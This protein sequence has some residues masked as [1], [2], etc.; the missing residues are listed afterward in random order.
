MSPIPWSINDAIC[1][2]EPSI[3]LAG[4]QINAPG[5]FWSTSGDG[6]FANATDMTTTYSFGTN[7]YSNGQVTLY[8]NTD[9][10]QYTG[11]QQG[12]PNLADSLII[13]I[14]NVATAEVGSNQSFCG[15]NVPTI[16]LNGDTTNADSLE[17]RIVSG[18]SGTFLPSNTEEDPT[19]LLDAF[20]STIANT[21]V[22]ELRARGDSICAAATDQMTI[23]ISPE[24]TIDA[25]ND[26]AVCANNP[27]INLSGTITEL[28]DVQ[29]SGGGGAFG[30]AQN[31]NTSYTLT[32]AEIASG[33]VQLTLSSRNEGNCNP[34]SDDLLIS[35][36]PAPTVDAGPDLVTCQT[37]DSVAV[38]GSYDTSISSGVTWTSSG[39]GSFANP[40][41]PNTTYILGPNDQS[42]NDTSTVVLTLTTTGSGNCNEESDTKNLV[43]TP[44]PVIDA[45]TN[46][47][48]CITNPNVS[49]AGTVTA[50]NG[51]PWPGGGRWESPT[52]PGSFVPN[53]FDPNATFVPNTSAILANTPFPIYFY[54]EGNGNCDAVNDSVL[55][56]WINPVVPEAGPDLSVCANNPTANITVSDGLGQ[57]P[58]VGQVWTS[59]SGHEG[60]GDS[61]VKNT[62]YT[63][64]GSEVNAGSATLYV[65]YDYGAGFN[66]QPEYD[67]VIINVTP[68]PIVDAGPDRSIC[69]NADTVDLSG[70][71]TGA[72][73]GQ[74][75]VIGGGGSFIPNNSDLNASFTPT[76]PVGGAT[77]DL[78]LTTTGNGNCLAER[79][80]MTVTVNPAPTMNIQSSASTTCKNNPA[81]NLR[82]GLAGITVAT[83][84][85][86]SRI[87]S[88]T[89]GSFIPDNTLNPSQDSVRYVPSQ[90]DLDNDSVT[91]VGV[92]TGNGDCNPIYDTV[93]IYFSPAP[94]VDAG[95]DDTICYNNPTVN[96]SGAVTVA[97][98][99]TWST[100]GG[101]TFSNPN[102]LNTS[103]T[104]TA[105]E[106]NSSQFTLTLT[107]TGNGN[108][109]PE[110]DQV[111]IFVR[112]APVVNAGSNITACETVNIVTLNGTFSN[113]DG[114]QWS[115]V[116]G[117]GSFVGGTDTLPNAQYQVTTADKNNGE[118]VLRAA[119]R[120]IEE[121]NPVS[122]QLRITFTPA[123][124]LSAGSNQVVCTNDFPV[125]LNGSSS[126][127]AS[128]QGG[129]GSFSPN[130]NS[131]SAQYTPAPSEVGS[132]VTLVLQGTAQGGCPAFT[133]SVELDIRQ[134]PSVS[135]SGDLQKCAQVSE[136]DL[137]ATFLGASGIEWD[138][139][140]GNGSFSPNPFATSVNYNVTVF[141]TTQDS[142]VFVVRTT[143][144]G[145]CSPARDTLTVEFL[146]PLI[147]SA[148]ASQTVCADD[149][150]VQLNGYSSTPAGGRWSTTNGSG[151]FSPNVNQDDAIYVFDPSDKSLDSIG[152]VFTTRGVPNVCSAIS[153]TAYIRFVQPPV[154]NAGSDLTVCADTN[155][156]ALSG[157]VSNASGG[158]WATTGSGT[159]SLN[160]SSLNTTYV[161]SDADTAA[162]TV[163]LV[164]ST[165]G[166]SLCGT[167]R[168]TLTLTITP[169]VRVDLG[170]DTVMC[171]SE[172]SINLSPSV[173][174][175]TGGS[176]TT[177][178]TG[179]FANPNQ[180]NT[181]YTP[182]AADKNNGFVSLTLST[183][184]NGQCQPR[185]DVLGINFQPV[186]VV[187]AGPNQ[188]TC[189][190]VDSIR[191]VGNLNNATTGAWSTSGSGN[192][193]NGNTTEDTYVISTADKSNGS[194]E[195]YFQATNTGACTA[196]QDTLVLTI[197]PSPTADAGADQTI[198]ADSAYVDLNGASISN[199]SGQV[200]TST[201]TGQF[202]PSAS[203]LAANYVPS[204]QDTANGSVS[205]ILQT[206]G[207]GACNPALDTMQVTIQ[208]APAVDAGGDQTVCAAVDSVFLSGTFRNAGGVRWRTS[209]TGTFAPSANQADARYIPSAQDTAVRSVILTLTST[210]NGLCN[211]VSDQ[212]TVHFTPAPTVD[213]GPDRQ[214]CYSEA[215]ITLA[216]FYR[217]AGGVRWTHDG[218]GA[219]TPSA[220]RDTTEYIFVPADI[221]R[222]LTFRVQTTNNGICSAVSDSFTLYIRPVPS[223]DAGPDQTVCA[224]VGSVPL[225]GD[226]SN[227]N[228]ILWTT[229]GDG[230]FLPGATSIDPAYS[231]GTNDIANGGV[232]LYLSSVGAGPCTDVL[233]SM[234]IQVN[235]A[236]TLAINNDTTVC[237]DFEGITLNATTNGVPGG[238]RW[239]TSGSGVFIPHDSASNPIYSPST[240]DINSGGVTINAATIQNGLCQAVNA[241][242]SLTIT[243][244][245]T[246]TVDNDKLLCNT[247]DT[248]VLSGTITVAPGGDW[249]TNGSGTFDD[250][251]SLNTVYRFSSADKSLD[252]VLFIL[253]AVDKGN[254][255]D[256]SDRFS[257]FWQ[258]SIRVEAGVNDTLCADDNNGYALNGSISNASGASWSTSGSGSF[259][260]SA[261]D[262]NATYYPSAADRSAGDV[263]LYLSTTD[264]GLCADVTDSL[265]IH[266]RPAP[267]VDAGSDQTICQDH[268]G[269]VAL[270]GTVNASVENILWTSSGTG[271]FDNATSLTANYTPSQADL[272]SLQPITLTLTTTSQYDCQPVISSMTIDVT[273]APTIDAGND[274]EVCAG[275]TSV[276][277]SVS[278]TVASGVSWSVIG[279]STGTFSNP[280]AVNTDYQPVDGVD[281]ASGNVVDI[282]VVTTGVGVCNPVADTISITFDTP[283]NADAGP[284]Q[285]V[286]T[287]QLPVQL[288]ASNTSGIWSGG[289]G[290]FIPNANT[291]NARYEPTS[292]ELSSGS[293]TLT[294]SPTAPGTCTPGAPDDV[295]ITFIQGPVVDAGADDTVCAND[296]LYSLSGTVGGSGTGGTWTSNGTGS[297][298]PNA[299]DLS[300]DYIPS[301]QDVSNG[302]VR[303]ILTSTGGTCPS[304]RDTM[305]LTITPTPVVDAGADRSICADAPSIPLTG[306]VSSEAGGGTWSVQSGSGSFSPHPDTLNASYVPTAADTANGF[307]VLRLTSR[308]NGRCNPVSDTMRIDFTDAPTISA[309]ADFTV[310][311]DTGSIQLN[312]QV[313]VANG[314]QW[315]TTGN[316]TFSP[317]RNV[318][319][320]TYVLSNGD[321]AAGSI[322]FYLV[323]TGNG[324]CQQVE[325]SF[326]LNI[327]PAVQIQAGND[328]TVC[329]DVGS[330]PLSGNVNSAAGGVVWTTSSPSSDP[331]TFTPSATDPN[332]NYQPSSTDSLNRSVTLTLTSTGSGL[333]RE[334]SDNMRIFFTPAPTV[335]V[336]GD[337]TAC[338]DVDSVQLGGTYDT[339]VSSGVLWSANGGDGSFVP[340]PTTLDA[341]YVPGSADSASGSVTLTLSTTG[342][343]D[344]NEVSKD[345]T[346]TLTPAP[347]LDAGS[348]QTVCADDPQV[349]LNPSVNAVVQAVA[350]DT[351]GIT[352]RFTPSPYVAN[353]TYVASN[354]DTANGQVVLYLNSTSVG[355]CKQVRDSMT[356]TILP[357]PAI[358]A[359]ADDTI[360]ASDVESQLS[361]RLKEITQ[362][363]W[364]SS[365]TGTFVPNANDPNARYRPSDQDDS[366]GRVDLTFTSID[367]GICLE[368]QDVTSLYID[369]IPTSVVNAGLDQT[370]CADNRNVILT[371]QIT[372]AVG[373]QWQTSGTGSFVPN[374]STLTATYVPSDG[375]TAAGTVVLTLTT[376]EGIGECDPVA[377]SM[378]LT[379]LPAPT[380]NAGNDDTVC[381]D[382]NAVALSPSLSA[383]ISA[384]EWSTSGTGVFTP[385]RFAANAAYIPSAQ[386]KTQ[387]TVG[388]TIRST[389]Q[390][391][392]NPVQDNKTLYITPT[393]IVD[394][395]SNQA[396]CQDVD[397]VYLSG[398]VLN[399]G[400]GQW[401]S[402]GSGTF[403]NASNLNTAYVPSA[404]ERN[405]G[406]AVLTLTST[407]NGLCNPVSDQLRIDMRP[408][409]SVDVGPDI[410]ICADVD[411]IPLSVSLANA[412]GVRWS[413]NGSGSFTPSPNVNGAAYVPSQAERN[414]LATIEIYATTTAG[415]ETCNPITDTMVVNLTPTPVVD[416]DDA[417]LC[418]DEQDGLLLFG[419]ATLAGAPIG[420]VW[421]TSGTGSFQPSR[422]SKTARYFP[423]QAD[424][425]SG[426]VVVT[427]TSVDNGSC[428]A[429]SKSASL[430]ITDL[431]TAYAGEDRFVCRGE[432]TSLSA[433][434]FKDIVGYQWLA[435]SG[436][437][438]S[439]SFSV[440]NLVINTDTSFV[441]RVTDDEGCEVYDTIQVFA[442]DPPTLNLPAAYCLD[443]NMVLLDA[444]PSAS[445]PPVNGTYTWYYEDTLLANQDGDTLVAERPGSY[446]VEYNFSF[447]SVSA[448]TEVNAAEEI[449]GEDKFVCVGSSTTLEVTDISGGTYEWQAEDGTVL[450]S[451]GHTQD[452]AIDFDSVYTFYVTMTDAIDCRSFDT[453]QVT[454]V[455]SPD[456]P[457][458]DTAI[459][460]GESITLVGQP[461][462]AVDTSGE[463]IYQWSR[464]GQ[465]IQLDNTGLLEV[466]ETG[467]YTLLYELG[468]CINYDTIEVTVHPLPVRDTTIRRFFQFCTEDPPAEPDTAFAYSTEVPEYTFTW[469]DFDSLQQRSLPITQSGPLVFQITNQFGC[470]VLDT[471]QID[472]GCPV[473][474]YVPDGFMPG[475]GAL[476]EDR[477]WRV[478][479]KH[480]DPDNFELMVFSRWGE[481]I[482]YTNNPYVGWDGTYRGR[483]MPA[484]TYNYILKFQPAD[485]EAT[486]KEAEL[487]R[488]AGE[489]VPESMQNLPSKGPKEVHGSVILVR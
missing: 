9:S 31:L 371:G 22:V 4:Q 423:S 380:I 356:V 373:G 308:L 64:S 379:I 224:D 63:L 200:W 420:A 178:G 226:S 270:T 75:S 323:S 411:S 477:E 210:S 91:I 478:F 229:S 233:D 78:V 335:S 137:S 80:T 376:T 10:A 84:A 237:A 324:S 40:T 415:I 272:D 294:F 277:L 350:W 234:H 331:G 185:S 81:F 465:V 342:S 141:D 222:T 353:A 56:T 374:D 298:S 198:C 381:A 391:I 314:G 426:S 369:P 125:Q 418:A 367:H 254:C 287:N 336:I 2:S 77:Y 8:L 156:V 201:G 214:A 159:F 317:N 438:L 113:A 47:A 62:T 104:P 119:S 284:D 408:I 148:G 306:S 469:V 123:G 403:V 5:T 157:S 29:W 462:N 57:A 136:I 256:V 412:T 280:S 290:N 211:A 37:V 325:D 177:S 285:S 155:G 195:L 316:G 88:G 297:F 55:I 282:R 225:D 116:T 145:A 183:T 132:V 39:D 199:A 247:Q 53:Q 45:G 472:E 252:S 377:D 347:S 112:P 414:A 422:F 109:V 384:I 165:T 174:V 400:G 439:D 389:A 179:T 206:T 166:A 196:I 58:S 219:F 397:T 6:S 108:C 406:Y 366:L 48:V 93:T 203:T 452:V 488:E 32:P 135:I 213:A 486:R 139:V 120:G 3:Q 186:P 457:N 217:N 100:S 443:T 169:V 205:L 227:L 476:E 161:P 484:G 259:A 300:A 154:A 345:L 60:F 102:Q 144:N 348:D 74:W 95:S 124:V 38:S 419:T 35:V 1:S 261:N 114:L 304:E 404:A 453:L 483:D 446:R 421:S 461:D 249:Q 485:L 264:N 339:T 343:G 130:R 454:G 251:D 263:T 193:V 208:P 326:Q 7:D 250:E 28:T 431:P 65:R 354:Q 487:L 360:C 126:T 315:S 378:Q 204:D 61:T 90:D 20:D 313:T 328:T 43:I 192:F 111:T 127:S 238:V 134:G 168:D 70:S 362:G 320:P 448:T 451:S 334:R 23:A 245:P 89:A 425:Q 151:S 129:N 231:L 352:G 405:Q 303:L 51:N 216:P 138:V 66:C 235:P 337:Q 305:F 299:L 209:G 121:C 13:D 253:T 17:W 407:D 152:V 27:T 269:S 437:V 79:D 394:A 73:G 255:I 162:G 312:G 295:L 344:C 115:I 72:T 466:S 175:A 220:T 289:S 358:F 46:Q 402:S 458:T 286:C 76:N 278:T 103:Y 338:S 232:M 12:C 364:N 146:D 236:P 365:G 105:T 94:T 455:P 171:S 266:I 18:G 167:R 15:N 242:M 444:D 340:G 281:N 474:V 450:S 212:M 202:F 59:A 160:S 387:G 172:T 25:G 318:L 71:V 96:L 322:M 330:I 456:F 248:V 470:S 83:G 327:D 106:L 409:P 133:D 388:L 441:L 329:A 292:A 361:G 143:G 257:V 310:C 118:V 16:A 44:G 273:P 188:T 396:L 68:E 268:T 386:D 267:T 260:P 190:N 41:D 430:V 181:S 471:I 274:I 180:L 258:D 372:V 187:D 435:T 460:N 36:T 429:Y 368:K 86:L 21:I 428:K 67:T 427:L 399:A 363:V 101:G 241:S 307:V 26:T 480:M 52:L 49:L 42:Q 128:W 149:V 221:G 24:P 147:V 69:A 296:S 275:L 173:S 228:Q 276:P 359:G 410:D 311:A 153:D 333:C 445:N 34:V 33:S 142:L 479:G 349:Q 383:N 239:S 434:T 473:T 375:D 215:R 440:S 288:N 481:I 464:D 475:D 482:F 110:Q 99:G 191:V 184:G 176:W 401:T 392:C 189:E 293:V 117:T 223:V 230:A 346:I 243:E 164:L 370:I 207:N 98:G 218:G 341:V 283:P 436:Q 463:A 246:V 158:Q 194:V 19:L 301:A 433:Q 82:V 459:C 382:Q 182:S 54:S 393:P 489:P 279:G 332:A 468:E 197:D 390:G 442:L 107:T 87:G 309:G 14:I 163:D 97:G 92:T 131:L 50:R 351:T 302:R 385:N 85:T 413:S 291:L 449:S 30:N 240:A 244:K 122:D 416:V 417:N 170:P 398:T 140:N 395:D 447:C 319:N 262:T 432:A 11:I 355:G 265:Q 271:S 424:I 357:E 321:T 150:D 467:V